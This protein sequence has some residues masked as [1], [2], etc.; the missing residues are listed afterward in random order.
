MKTTRTKKIGKWHLPSECVACGAEDSYVKARTTTEK[1]CH[2]EAFRVEH[3]H[4]KCSQCS[5][6]ILG[7]QEAE[8]AARAT[9]AAYQRA[10]GLLTAADLQN[11][12]K[13]AG[14]SQSDLAERTS[15]GIATIKR[16][17][18]GMTVQTGANDELLRRVLGIANSAEL[19]FVICKRECV[20]SLIPDSKTDPHPV[21][22]LTVEKKPDWESWEQETLAC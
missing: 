18:A 15:L 2:G 17:E 12:R 13:V 7:P 22:H 5:V 16:L 11:A 4:W 10:N 20:R 6:G 9:V 19:A 1:V 14:W 8:E 3:A 21:F